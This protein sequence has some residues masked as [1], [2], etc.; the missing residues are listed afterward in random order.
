MRKLLPIIALLGLLVLSAC[1]YSMGEADHSVLAPQYRTLAVSG[2]DNPST[3]TWL[4]PMVRKLLRDELT[5]RGVIKWTDDTA[6]ADAL[7]HIT[8]ERYSRPTSLEGGN[9]E[10]LRSSASIK[11]HATITSAIDGKELWSSGSISESWSFY[12]GQESQADEEVTRLV[13]RRLA[14]RMSENY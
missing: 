4:E 10:T 14:D 8:I 12:S 1:G 2:V 3:Q 13:I 7:I 11:L 5:R 6:K 9:N